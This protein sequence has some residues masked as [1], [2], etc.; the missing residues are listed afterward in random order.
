MKDLINKSKNGLFLVLTP[1]VFFYISQNMLAGVSGRINWKL[2]IVNIIFYYLISFL[3]TAVIGKAK[4]SLRILTVFFWLFSLINAY[5]FEFRGSYIMPWDLFSVGTAMNVA[6]NFSYIPTVRMIIVTLIFA[7]LFIILGKCD[8]SFEKFSKK[9]IIRTGIALLSV[10]A[11]FCY[12]WL[13]HRNTVKDILEIYDIQFDMDGLTKKNGLYANFIYELKYLSVEK[14][15]GYNASAEKSLLESQEIVKPRV[16]VSCP[17]I[18]VIM[19]EAFS[20]PKIDAEFTTNKDYMPFVH[21]LQEGAENTITGYINVSVIG[22]NTPNT[23]FE[24]LTGDSMGFLPRSSIPYQQYI[25]KETESIPSYLAEKYGYKTIA[26]HPY[27]SSGWNRTNVYPLLGFDEMYFLD[28][29]FD[30]LGLDTVRNYISDKAFFEQIEK[31]VEKRSTDAPVFSFNVTMQNH[32]GYSKTFD[33]LPWDV[34]LDGLE[35]EEDKKSIRVNNYLNLIKLTD[36][37]LKEMT[38]YYAK[39]DRPAII[40]FFGDHQPDPNVLESIWNQNGKSFESLSD[41][42]TFNT[43]RVPFVIWANYD[44]EEM[45]G[46]EISTNYLGNLLLKEAGIDL[47]EYR[48]FT[49]K[50][51]EKYPVISAIRAVDAEGKSTV[52]KDL[53]TELSDYAKM[54]YYM[55]FESADR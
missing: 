50:F 47:P 8:F 28:G 45:S 6:G 29:Y 35:D 37:A 18:I 51:S 16:S 5:V 34:R 38:E 17:D 30:D 44:I 10:C 55:L 15:A 22:G 43:Y 52:T 32:S 33:N 27:D 26:M 4:I 1:I 54:Q 23:E 42:D 7:A 9:L 36:D 48:S 2:Q 41:E 25:R 39:S 3:L 21:S 12:T 20:D 19:D 40:V 31:E 46:L 13:L 11:L 14:P 53:S 49:D 24:F